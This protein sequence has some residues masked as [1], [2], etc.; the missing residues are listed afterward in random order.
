DVLEW[1]EDRAVERAPGV[2]TVRG[3]TGAA[4]LGWR[5]RPRRARDGRRPGHRRRWDLER[6]PRPPA[7]PLG[8]RGSPAVVDGG[9]RELG[10]RVARRVRGTRRARDHRGPV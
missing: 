6:P 10:G 5:E 3:P 9:A 1:R 2:P 8:G 7:P 4:Q